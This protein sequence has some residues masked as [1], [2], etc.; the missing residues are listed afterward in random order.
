LLYREKV[1]LVVML[2]SIIVTGA[3]FD[4]PQIAMWVG[5]LFAGYSAVANDSIQTIG[6]FI[7]FDNIESTTITWNVIP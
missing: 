2:I 4:Q 1:F 6:T 5:F 3:V 7:S